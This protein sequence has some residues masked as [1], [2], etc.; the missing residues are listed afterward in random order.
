MHKIL[1]RCQPSLGILSSHEKICSGN[2]NW[3]MS[4]D[5]EQRGEF[6]NTPDVDV[7]K[8]IKN[9]SIVDHR[10]AVNNDSD[11]E[12]AWSAIEELSCKENPRKKKEQNKMFKIKRL[13]KLK[14]FL[15]KNE[16]K[17]KK[18]IDKKYSW[19]QETSSTGKNEFQISIHIKL[20]STC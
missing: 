10:K 5:L 19:N 12:D 11:H 3:I 14:Q 8:S 2:I 18:D 16:S 20:P 17:F 13:Q 9:E 7:I 6:M 1:K 4:K 15:L